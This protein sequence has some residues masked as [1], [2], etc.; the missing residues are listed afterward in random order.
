DH[1]THVRA[2]EMERIALQ[3]KQQEELLKELEKDNVPAL[4]S[5]N[6]ALLEHLE[7][8]REKKLAEYEHIQSILKEADAAEHAYS[9]LRDQQILFLEAQVRHADKAKINNET[10]Y[11]L[12]RK[13]LAHKQAV[14]RQQQ[15]LFVSKIHQ[16]QQIFGKYAV[17][18]I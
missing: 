14:L 13:D 3:R 9:Q 2:D 18:N 16:L 1:A 12:L 11:Q 5:P 6:A 8:L 4:N 17:E 10:D 7:A 15:D